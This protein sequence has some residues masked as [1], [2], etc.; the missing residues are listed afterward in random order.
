MRE[1]LRDDVMGDSKILREKGQGGEK[2]REKGNENFG[3]MGPNY[4]SYMTTI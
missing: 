3:H 1:T 2:N 4:V